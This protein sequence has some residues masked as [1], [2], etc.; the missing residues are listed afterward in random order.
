MIKHSDKNS[1]K[2]KYI[3][4]ECEGLSLAVD[5]STG[6]SSL[7]SELKDKARV[8]FTCAFVPP[9][10]LIIDSNFINLTLNK[11]I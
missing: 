2:K 6:Q 4:S 7:S 5:A 11:V 1:W 8:M 10:N 9:I 3:I